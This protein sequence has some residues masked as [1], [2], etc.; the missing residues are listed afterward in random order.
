VRFK[1]GGTM[2]PVLEIEVDQVPV[3]FEHHVVLWKEP[4]VEV[5]LKPMA[6][7]FSRMLAGM[8]IFMTQTHGRGRI[9]F[10]RDGAGELFAIHLSPGGS[11]DVREHQFLAATATV[12]FT[13]QYVEGAAN[14]LFG[15]AGFFM[16]TFWTEAATGVLWLHGYG[17]VFELTLGPGEVI[18]VEPGGWIYKDHSVTMQTLT[19]GLRSGFLSSVSLFWNRFTGPG[20]VGIQSMYVHYPSAG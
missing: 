10:S 12:Q 13:F 16:D 2:V 3:Y 7:A 5:M 20:R 9:A 8:P 6:G 15:G 17:N 4:S 18:D 19:Q 14:I 1:I 11:I